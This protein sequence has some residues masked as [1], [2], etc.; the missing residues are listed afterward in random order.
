MEGFGIQY[1]VDKA[2]DTDSKLM[3]MIEQI[4]ELKDNLNTVTSPG[5]YLHTWSTCAYCKIIMSLSMS[6]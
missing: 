3:Y 2:K 1:L 5:T 4:H 6:K